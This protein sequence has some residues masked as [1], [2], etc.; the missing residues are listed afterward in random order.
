MP[1]IVGMKAIKGQQIRILRAAATQQ[2]LVTATKL[3]VVLVVCCPY[4]CIKLGKYV[5]D[6]RGFFTLQSFQ[7]L[8]IHDA[9]FNN[10][11]V[12]MFT[13]WI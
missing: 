11:P 2:L 9:D 1:Q 4:L 3:W 8:R 10:F 12:V 6:V 13:N 5:S 7:L